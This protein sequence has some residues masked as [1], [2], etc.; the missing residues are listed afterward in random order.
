MER[1]IDFTSPK[2][3]RTI[4][5]IA[6]DEIF[7]AWRE[8]EKEDGLLMK[9]LCSGYTLLDVVVVFSISFSLTESIEVANTIPMEMRMVV[10]YTIN[11]LAMTS[12][13]GMSSEA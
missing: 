7:V 3:C 5:R 12:I 13:S 2:C 10:M 11:A 4:S 6:A 8:D 9:V 1:A